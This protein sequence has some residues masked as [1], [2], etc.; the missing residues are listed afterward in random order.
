MTTPLY[1]DHTTPPWVTSSVL[2]SYMTSYSGRIP[3]VKK[4]CHGGKN[5][6]IKIK[7]DTESSN[8]GWRVLGLVGLKEIFIF[9]SFH[10]TA[11]RKN[12]GPVQYILLKNVHIYSKILSMVYTEDKW[13]NMYKH[14][15]VLQACQKRDK[16]TNARVQTTC[17]ATSLNRC[18]HMTNAI[19]IFKWN[20]P[21]LRS[22]LLLFRV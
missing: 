9:I 2:L 11:L 15:S 10:D 6:K 22:P 17:T 18:K 12:K 3:K 7:Y 1:A 13:F 21:N 20:R 8:T 5:L 19:L 16:N 14:I 4:T